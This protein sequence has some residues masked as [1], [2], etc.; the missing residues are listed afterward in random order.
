[1]SLVVGGAVILNSQNKE[2]KKNLVQG[3]YN[4]KRK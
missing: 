1:M 2:K 4:A 3:L